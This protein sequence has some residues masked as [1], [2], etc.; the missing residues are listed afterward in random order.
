MR[1]GML[2][3]KVWKAACDT[4]NSCNI[5]C[6]MRMVNKC[7]VSDLSSTTSCNWR[8]LG[9]KFT[10]SCCLLLVGPTG[11]SGTSMGTNGTFVVGSGSTVNANTG[12]TVYV[13]D[14]AQLV[15]NRT[16][17]TTFSLLGTHI[18]TCDACAKAE[19]VPS[20]YEAT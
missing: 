1:D 5:Q 20:D 10:A 9:M 16:S 18:C 19:I 6:N 2:E 15:D 3:A 4:L 8:M 12:S 7:S 17:N 13:N 14:G 11:P